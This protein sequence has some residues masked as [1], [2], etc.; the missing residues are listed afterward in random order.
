[1]SARNWVE[2]L[3]QDQI[4][5]KKETLTSLL[6][7]EYYDDDDGKEVDFYYGIVSD[8]LRAVEAN[9]ASM[10]QLEAIEE[11]GPTESGNLISKD[12]RDVLVKLN[13]V[14]AVYVKGEF[15][16]ACTVSGHYALK[17]SNHI[18]KNGF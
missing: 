11:L 9:N 13:F 18:D 2:N 7:G 10:E 3:T 6:F 16:W 1:M 5:Q 4:T 14:T 12:A 8:T 15:L 17:V